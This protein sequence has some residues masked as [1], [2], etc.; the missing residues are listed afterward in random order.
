M[1]KRQAARVPTLETAWKTLE[2]RACVSLRAIRSA[3]HHAQL[4]RFMNDL[5][6]EI[7]DD[8][9][10]ALC[11]LLDMVTAL[12]RDYEVQHVA[13]PDAA[14]ADVLRALME[15]NGLRQ[16]DLAPIFG[17][18]SNVSEILNGKR[19]INARQARALGQRFGV[20]AAA[21]V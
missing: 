13:M 2:A 18:Q 12:V 7:G 15:A 17:A 9:S 20:S 6:D 16:L 19:Q 4:V 21:F 3:R 8:E 14:P 10:H 11:G 5:L 1:T